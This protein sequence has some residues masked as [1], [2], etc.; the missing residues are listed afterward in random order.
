MKTYNIKRAFKNLTCHRCKEEINVAEKYFLDIDSKKWSCSNCGMEG[1]IYGGLA[2]EKDFCEDG[3]EEVIT[4]SVY[5]ERAGK[6]ESK[7]FG[8]Y[9]NS[10]FKEIKTTKV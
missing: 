6:I 2:A 7:T 3:A 10:V 4:I 5:L 1:S 8:L 9:K